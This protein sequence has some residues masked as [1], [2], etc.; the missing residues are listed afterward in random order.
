MQVQNV[1]GAGGTI[2]L[3]QF[4][5]SKDRDPSLMVAGFGLVGAPVINK[6][7]VTLSRRP[8][9]PV[10]RASISR[11]SLPPNRPSSPSLTWS[12]SSS[13]IRARSPGEALRMA[14]PTTSCAAWSPRPA[15]AM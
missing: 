12:A 14:L 4:I 3:A 8:R 6:S 15:V 9:L 7:P 13:R 10:S 1:P 5:N 11:C 2:G